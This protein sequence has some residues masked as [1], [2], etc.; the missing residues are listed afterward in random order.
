MMKVLR[1]I[2]SHFT[3]IIARVSLQD[4]R[5]LINRTSTSLLSRS[6]CSIISTAE[7]RSR[8]YSRFVGRLRARVRKRGMG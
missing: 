8:S 1:M 2:G 5:R 4:S 6:I 7:G 3:L